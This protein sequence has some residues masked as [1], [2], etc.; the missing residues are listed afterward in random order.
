MAKLKGNL[1]QRKL[2]ISQ[3]K[4]SFLLFM[5]VVVGVRGRGGLFKGDMYDYV[6]T[7]L[8]VVYFVC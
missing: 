3:L 2:F 6:Y 5:G 7:Q 1:S 8:S 4:C